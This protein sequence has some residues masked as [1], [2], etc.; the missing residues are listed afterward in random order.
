MA[1]GTIVVDARNPAQRRYIYS[2]YWISSGEIK[3]L[4]LGSA[5]TKVGILFSFP[6]AKYGSSIIL[7]EKV[8]VQVTEGFAGGTITLEIGSYTIETDIVTT[9]GAL[10][11]V[12]VDHYMAHTTTGTVA[13]AA[14]YFPL[15]NSDWLA[16]RAAETWAVAST[17]IPADH[18]VPCVGVEVTSDGTMTAGKMRAHFLITEM[19][20]L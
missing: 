19:P 14:N 3:A 12:D 17:I 15:A 8:C 4:D 7:V 2:P 10:V 18:D 11:E 6:A 1:T 9:G 13:S 16:A 5:E 20:I